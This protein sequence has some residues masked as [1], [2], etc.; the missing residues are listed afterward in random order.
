MHKYRMEE[1]Q[2]FGCLIAEKDLDV[3]V[4]HKLNTSQLYNAIAWKMP[5]MWSHINRNTVCK[6]QEMIV[7]FVLVLG[8]ITVSSFGIL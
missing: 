7:S 4:D 1:H 5:V 2:L 6:I 8:S 3:M